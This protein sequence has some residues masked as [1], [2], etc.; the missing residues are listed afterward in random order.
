MVNIIAI[1]C[2]ILILAL[3]LPATGNVPTI[4][5]GA[6]YGFAM[7]AFVSIG[8]SLMAQISDVREIGV[9]TGLLFSCI[10]FG[11]LGGN[12]VAGSLVTRYKGEYTGLQIFAGVIMFVSFV[13]FVAARWSLVGKKL[14]AK[15]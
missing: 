7:G 5:F 9:R 3:W 14:V 12:P 13:I 6:L 8:P 2:S 4:I 11:A 15:V 1:S 10:A